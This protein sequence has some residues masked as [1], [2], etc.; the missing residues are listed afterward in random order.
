MRETD[1]SGIGILRKG[2][3][4]ASPVK[5]SAPWEG[6]Q[7]ADVAKGSQMSPIK[8][9]I[10][11]DHALVREG[12]RQLLISQADM[13]V[14]GEACDGMEALELARSLRPDILVLDITMPQM[15]GFEAIKLIGD[16]VPR[17]LIV[18]LSM[19]EKGPY[20]QRALQAGA[21]GYVQKGEPSKHL[22]EAIRTV[23]GGQCFLN[24]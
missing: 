12:L 2:A 13:D 15:G 4:V 17:T 11:D 23:H 16:A 24:G 7:V 21:R 18:V 14:V 9:L 8:V 3:K 22:L 1:D 6:G 10:A 20:M 19:Y 5:I